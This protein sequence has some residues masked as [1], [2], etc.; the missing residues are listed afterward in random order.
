MSSAIHNHGILS[1]L[2]HTNETHVISYLWHE[3]ILSEIKV[4]DKITTVIFSYRNEHFTENDIYLN[5]LATMLNELSLKKQVIYVLQAP[6][7]EKHIF[8][9]IP[10]LG[11]TDTSIGAVTLDAWERLF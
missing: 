3:K 2:E 8:D 4:N 10:R 7:L 5:S 6:L 9:Y 11:K 1:E